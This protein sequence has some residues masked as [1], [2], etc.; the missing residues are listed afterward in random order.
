MH[1]ENLSPCALASACPAGLS[2]PVGSSHLQALVAALNRADVALMPVPPGPAPRPIPPW[3]L[4]SGKAEIPCARMHWE[5]ASSLCL[6]DLP[7]A[8]APVPVFG[9]LEQAAA[10]RARQ[11]SAAASR[12]ARST[13]FRLLPR[14][15]L[16]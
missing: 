8:P 10:T 11:A 9:G 6:A 15:P 14:C 4:G 7:P 2:V 5:K 3:P 1:R 13:P 12:Q 16:P